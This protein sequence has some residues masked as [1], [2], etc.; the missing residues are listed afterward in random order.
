MQLGAFSVRHVPD[1]YPD[2]CNAYC[3]DD[4]HAVIVGWTE[5]PVP[6]EECIYSN[7]VALG[8]EVIEWRDAPE[9]QPSRSMVGNMVVGEYG[10]KGRV[11][12]GEDEVTRWILLILRVPH[13]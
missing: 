3:H 9:Y 1:K 11:Q 4:I 8:Y 5:G 13:A 12:K 2:E 6:L 7:A 10:I